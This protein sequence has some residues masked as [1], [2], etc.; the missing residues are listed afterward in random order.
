MIDFSEKPDVIIIA[1]GG[2]SVEDL[3]SFNSEDL[4]KS[5][6][7]SKIP[8][9]TAIG[10]ETDTTIID[11]VSDLRAPTPTAAAEMCVPVRNDLIKSLSVIESNMNNSI[12]QTIVFNY[13][14]FEC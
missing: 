4:A 7:N 13:E 10:H 14:R 11:F 1:R 9:I 8:I 2:G 12:K 3:M 6:F 5:V